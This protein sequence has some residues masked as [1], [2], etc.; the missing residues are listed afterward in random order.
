MIRNLYILFISTLALP[1]AVILIVIG[2]LSIFCNAYS[3]V[4]L[5]ASRVP[6]LFGQRLRF[7]YYKAT[8]KH[9]GRDVVFKYG[10]FCQYPT[11]SIGNR[12]LIG[13]FN[14]LG[15]VEMGDDIVIGGYVNFISGTTQHSFENE[16]QT[17]STQKAAGR[18]MITIGSDV[19]IGS[20]AVIAASVGTRCVIGAGSVLVKQAENQSI[21]AGNPA[22][23]IKKIAGAAI[24]S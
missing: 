1:F 17:I 8:L 14:A 3:E 23:V 22:R 24:E 20:N 10:S 2:K 4:S 18:T 13:Y 16:E 12:V 6:F 19:W 5:I 9:L 15:E 11:A 21:Y 7:F